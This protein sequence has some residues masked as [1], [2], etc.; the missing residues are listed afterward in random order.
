MTPATYNIEI[1]KGITLSPL[2]LIM[3][4]DNGTTVDLTGW[5][6]YAQVRK[7][8]TANE[9]VFNLSPEITDPS[10]GEI[11]IT[12][13]DEFTDSLSLGKFG[14]DLVLENPDGERLGPFLEGTV[15]VVA[16]Y[17]HTS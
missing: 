14:W 15:T 7:T 6:A 4:D 1:R 8:K 10:A 17:T 13:T 3:K 5:S 9:V 2:V 11:T 12:L 16:T